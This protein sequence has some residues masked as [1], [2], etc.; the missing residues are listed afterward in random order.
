M[1]PFH[2]S[3][4]DRP[5]FHSLIDELEIVFD[6]YWWDDEKLREL[7]RE[8]DERDGRRAKLLR[9]RIIA[10]LGDDR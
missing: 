5:Y 10:I 9:K 3:H 4:A 1:Y 8:L 6:S 7:L 2:L